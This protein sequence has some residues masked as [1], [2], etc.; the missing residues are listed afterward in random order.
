[1]SSSEDWKER[2]IRAEALLAEVRRQSYAGVNDFDN[3]TSYRLE[4]IYAT[5]SGNTRPLGPA[6]TK[7]AL[8]AKFDALQETLRR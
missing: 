5:A 1:M 3:F 2:A 4:C 6:W 7:E 8:T